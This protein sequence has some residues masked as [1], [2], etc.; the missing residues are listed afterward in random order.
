MAYRPLTI[1]GPYATG[2]H[3]WDSS[4]FCQGGVRARSFTAVMSSISRSEKSEAEPL[5]REQE[6]GNV[7]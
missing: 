3:H 4:T 6:G 7:W 1:H 2:A 5:P